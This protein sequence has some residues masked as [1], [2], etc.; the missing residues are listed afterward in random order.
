MPKVR[1]LVT[2]CSKTNVLKFGIDWVILNAN[3]MTSYYNVTFNVTMIV[4][5]KCYT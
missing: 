4:F 3:I 5:I 2:L 1:G